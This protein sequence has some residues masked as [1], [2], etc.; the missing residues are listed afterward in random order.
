MRKII[1]RRAFDMGYNLEIIK[2]KR[3]GPVN[4]KRCK[5]TDNNLVINEKE[6]K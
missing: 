4:K 2:I 5:K 1:I 6:K 3:I